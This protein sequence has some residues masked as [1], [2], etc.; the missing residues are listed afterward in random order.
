MGREINT[1]KKRRGNLLSFRG[2]RDL[3]IG[4]SLVAL[5]L[6]LL[7][8]LNIDIGSTIFAFALAVGVFLLIRTW[9]RELNWVI[10]KRRFFDD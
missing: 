10:L 3:L 5:P 1:Q 7:V 4:G 6:V 9:S 8:F 2:K